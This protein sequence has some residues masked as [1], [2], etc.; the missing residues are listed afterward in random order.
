MRDHDSR[1]PGRVAPLTRLAG[2]SALSGLLLALSF[3]RWDFS[4]LAFIA[5]IPL[6]WAS[7]NQP[8]K[9]SFFLGWFAGLVYFLGTLSWVTTPMHYYGNLPW[10]ASALFMLLFVAYLAVYVGCFTLFI[11]F[12]K[13]NLL[14][15]A[16]V[17]FTALEYLRGH[18]LTGFPWSALG[19]SQYRHLRL[20]Q[21]ADITSVYGVTFLI[22][23]VNAA[24]FLIIQTARHEKK[25]VR[26]PAVLAASLILV[27]LLYGTYRLSQPMGNGPPISAGVVQG[28]ID[29]AIKW[30]PQMR[31]ETIDKYERLSL[32][33]SK[34]P[35]LVIWPESATPLFF[36]NEP[37]YQEKLL[38]LTE[39]GRFSL[40][41]GSPSFKIIPSGQIT[42]LNSA[43]LLGGSAPGQLTPPVGGRGGKGEHIGSPLRA[44]TP[45]R[46]DKMHLVP[47][48][49]YVPLQS[50]LFFV[51]KMVEGIGNFIPGDEAIVMDMGSVRIGTVICYE[52]IFPE[53]VRR[54]VQNGANV[55]VTI[56][57]DAWFGRS[58]APYQHFSMV[59]F[60]AIE[61]RVPFARAA[62]TGISGFIDAHGVVLQQTD[63]FVEDARFQELIPGD[64]ETFYSKY[65]DFFAIGCV[66]ILITLL[67]L[68]YGVFRAAPPKRI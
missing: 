11:A 62:N 49:E 41:F 28:N 29:Q 51:N 58:A 52:V 32:S 55:M 42:L 38:N 47:F 34:Q 25:I 2:A 4:L 64:R 63:I 22:V 18:L 37:V 66:L 21:I 8:L 9:N 57:N 56:T 19:Y 59:V 15:V 39:K 48:G 36:Q 20:I 65:G 46:Y 67:V 1:V 16:P 40:L 23:F 30:D 24:L 43:Y 6:F 44:S 26:L 7:E 27:V 45:P 53:L 17:G 12:I 31:D 10:F 61:N 60:R 3:P 33:F 68:S 50:I 14:L 13:K 35:Q 5:F 54:F